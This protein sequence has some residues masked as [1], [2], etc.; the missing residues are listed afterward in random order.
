MVPLLA[1]QLLP[2]L[3]MEQFD[4]LPIQCRHIEHMHE[5]VWFRKNN[6]WQN[7][8]SENLDNF[9]L[10]RCLYMHRWCLHGPIN[11]YYSFWWSNLILCL[12]NVDT[13]DICIKEF[14]SEKNNFWQNDSSENLDN[15]SLIRRLH[16]HRWCL[17]WPI[18]FYH[19][20]WWSNLILCLY[21]ADTLNICMTEFGSEKIIFW[22][23]GSCE[24]LDSFSLIRLLYMH[25]WCLHG[26]INSYYSF[27]WSNLIL[28]LYNIDTLNICMK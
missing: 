5:G 12:Y 16:M 21:N 13:L 23:N 6:F 8:S 19:S 26:P 15:F 24:N 14:G 25:R 2:Q 22:Q 4:T 17:H 20:F 1:D 28:C 18:N 3:L 7:D 9:S 11:S 10:I 27:W